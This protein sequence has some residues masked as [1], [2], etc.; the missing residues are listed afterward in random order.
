M[1][2]TK[3]HLVHQIGLFGGWQGRSGERSRFGRWERAWVAR[4]AG[5]ARGDMPPRARGC[6]RSGGLCVQ[7]RRGSPVPPWHTAAK[8]RGC[9]RSGG[10]RWRDGRSPCHPRHRKRGTV[11][12][13]ER[14]G[15]AQRDGSGRPARRP[16]QKD[17]KRGAVARHAARGGRAGKSRRRLARRTGKMTCKDGGRGRT[18]M[19]PERQRLEK[20][21]GPSNCLGENYFSV[22][23]KMAIF[24]T[25]NGEL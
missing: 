19:H 3:R 22:S 1:T 24:M 5:A 11:N 15:R 8:G 9:R 6:L 13:S 4:R 2:E 14:W 18:K 20:V 16:W 21:L 17:R 25:K 23:V 7:G 12:G 10:R